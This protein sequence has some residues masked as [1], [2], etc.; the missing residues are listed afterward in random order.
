MEEQNYDRALANIDSALAQDS[1]NVDAYLMRA[2]ILREQADSTMAPEEYKDLYSRAR[3]AEEAAIEFDPGARS[4]IQSQRRLTY[5][6]QSQQGAK[7]FQRARQSSDP[8]D[9]RQAS[10]HFG[11]ASATEPDSASVILNEAFARLN[12]AQSQEEGGDMAAAIPILE[13]YIETADEPQKNA[14]D[15]L[16]ALYLQNGQNEEAIDLLETA[17]QDLSQRAPYIQVGGS[18]GLEYSGSVESNGSSQTVEGTT[19]DR[20]S[21]DDASGT[22]SGT[23]EKTQEKG[24]LRVQLFYQGTAVAD[25]M[26]T[27]GSGTIS[28]DLSEQAPLAEIEGRLL[29]AYNQAG[30]TEKA[31]QEY[32]N[33]IEENPDNVTY[34]YN[35]GSM[36]L[37]ANRLDEAIEQLQEAVEL[38]SGNVKAQYNLGAA[39]S[40]KAR[41][42]QDSLQT[43]NDSMR[44]ISEAAVEENR[45]PTEEEEQ[46]VN[47]LDKQVQ[48][49]SEE[50]RE[51]YRQAVPPLER[52]RQMADTDGDFRQN[53]CSALVTA[54]VQLEQVQK[55][56]EYEDCAGMQIQ[57]QGEGGDSGGGN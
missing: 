37:Q 49:L 45:E 2:Q 17:R 41:Q 18:R 35:Y 10:A 46:R 42:Y 44:S 12:M 7:A 4:D 26:L 48:A 43:L 33:Q 16:S 19:P 30:M 25:T 34:R 57:T 38:E 40:N 55:A 28:A 13:R 39:Y 5:A 6:Q 15:I 27:A 23:F 56:Q 53:A 9:Y 31:M 11:A 54:Y 1:A 29:N 50:M 8:A 47:E 24:Q 20:I 36:L 32:R 3:E 22:V 52:A 14:Y 21:L 51:Y